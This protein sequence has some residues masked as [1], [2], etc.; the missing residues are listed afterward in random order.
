MGNRNS[1]VKAL[2]KLKSGKMSPDGITAEILK[3][4]P[5][6]CK[7]FLADGLAQRC[8]VRVLQEWMI[9]IIP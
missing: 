3:A 7:A 1:F 8:Q 9:S 2:A 5:E 6:K 4:L